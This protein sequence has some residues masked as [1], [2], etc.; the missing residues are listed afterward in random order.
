MKKAQK[1][2]ILAAMKG[3]RKLLWDQV[4]DHD[5]LCDCSPC[6]YAEDLLAATRMLETEFEKK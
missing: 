2:F 6:C 3:A 4:K 1:S 5:E